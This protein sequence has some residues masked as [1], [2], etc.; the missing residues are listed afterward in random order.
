MITS[1]KNCSEIQTP[2][3]VFFPKIIRQNIEAM[4]QIAGDPHRLW[5]HI[6]THKSKEI[7]RIQKEY[8]IN[9]FKCA[10]LHEAHI[11][12]EEGATDILVAMQLHGQNLKNYLSLPEK[13][14]VS[15]FYSL[16]DNMDTLKEMES[17][18]KKIHVWMDLNIGMNRT[19]IVPGKKAFDLYSAIK[20]SHFLQFSG[21]HAYDGHIREK[22]YKE[23]KNQCDTGFEILLDF[24]EK[25]G[26]QADIIAG[27]SPTFPYHALRK[28]VF[29]S[30]G[31]IPLWD[32]GYAGLWPESPFIPAALLATR[33]V[34]KPQPDL[35]C[36]DIGH[37]AV[38]AEMPFPRVKVLELEDTA[39]QISQSEEHLVI[40]TTQAENFKTG[41]MLT[42]IPLHI[43][44]TVSR[45]NKVY[46]AD[47]ESIKGMWNIDAQSYFY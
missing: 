16:I 12:A 6:K 9:K 18:K 43:C 20:E 40:Q 14:P 7:I 1:L 38:A 45:Y 25:Y 42:A 44:P 2:A 28:N 17:Y 3:L 47:E 39:T 32:Y 29:L 4:I 24:N 19:G 35:L 27:G 26:I 13:Y 11:L 33:I 23:R 5:P 36:L 46:I 8:G 41:D 30:P 22:D 37:K 31:T 34:S 10:T 15:T 21:L